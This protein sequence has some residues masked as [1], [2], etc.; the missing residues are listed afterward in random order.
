M[1]YSKLIWNH[2]NPDEPHQ[3]LSEHGDDGWE[4][5]KVELHRDGSMGYASTSESH[6]GAKL[7]LIQCPPDDEVN[8][9]PEFNVVDV[10]KQ[11]F[12]QMW[13]KA[14]EQ[15]QPYGAEAAGRLS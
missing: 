4:L 2:T 14:H 8:L 13:Q 7:S 9:P 1:R 12:E 5:R 6:L 15:A 10:S 3:I 11:E